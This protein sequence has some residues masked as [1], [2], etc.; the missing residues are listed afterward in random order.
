MHVADGHSVNE[1]TSICLWPDWSFSFT[2]YTSAVDGA[3]GAM[4]NTAGRA[5]LSIT[6]AS[7]TE[8]VR[9]RA[10][11]WFFM[12]AKFTKNFALVIVRQTEPSGASN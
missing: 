2:A 9:A 7:C 6:I 12:L 10:R 11:Q 8:K 4:L 1:T 5:A 3:L